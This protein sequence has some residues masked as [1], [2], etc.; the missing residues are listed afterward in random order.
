MS[1]SYN[2]VYA[3]EDQGQKIYTVQPHDVAALTNAVLGK[4]VAK[5][6]DDK[7]KFLKISG[8]LSELLTEPSCEKPAEGKG[9]QGKLQSYYKI[10]I[11]ME[12]FC[13][14]KQQKQSKR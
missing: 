1:V 5:G 14:E 3:E 9:C 4:T 6:K 10:E 8:I 11:D 13:R 7:G 2:C 12:A